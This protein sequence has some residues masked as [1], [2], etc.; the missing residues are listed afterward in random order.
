VWQLFCLTVRW[1]TETLR[2]ALRTANV[3]ANVEEISSAAS[4][5][6][7]LSNTLVPEIRRLGAARLDQ[8]SDFDAER[9]P[10]AERFF[11]GGQ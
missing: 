2:R 11:H 9:F 1:P 3:A 5:S 6:P 7:E 4:A 8:D 10:N